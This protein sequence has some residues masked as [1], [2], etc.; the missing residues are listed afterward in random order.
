MNPI[1]AILTLFASLTVLLAPR[2]VAVIGVFA[3]ICY[4]TQ[5]QMLNVGGFHFHAIRIVLLAGF[6]RIIVRG[7]LAKLKLSNIDWGVIA[8][9][10]F[11]LVV[12]GLRTGVWQEPVGISYNILLSYFVFRCFITG[13]DDFQELL[14]RLALLIVPL[15]LC[16]VWESLTGHNVFSFMGGQIADWER[17][18]RYRC[19]GSFRGPHTAG[20]FGATLMPLF[21]SLFFINLQRRAAAVA[22]FI[23]A[24]AITYTSNSS[25]PLLAYL[26]C[27]VGLGFWPLRHRMKSVRMGIVAFLIVMGFS[28]KAPIWYIFSKISDITGGDGWH[29]SYLMEQ[30]FKH[31]SDWWFAG[32]DNTAAWAATQ[33]SWGGADITN[34]YVSCAS[35]AGL[36]CLVLFILILVRCFRGLGLA[37]VLARDISPQTEGLL[38]CAGCA[39][40]GHM[41]NLFSVTYFDQMDVAWWGFLAII[42]TITSSTEKGALTV[43]STQD[44]QETWSGGQPAEE[45]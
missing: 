24:T 22:G 21:V 44:I 32:T 2:R 23:A 28:M 13:W 39:L 33:M 11:T 10:F 25:G 40:F 38:W 45:T 31:F 6:I 1:G 26:S 34:Q 3:A 5:G 43:K 4:I 8:Y 36:G 7:E 16:M 15:A 18:G 27:V 29:R 19:V 12:V 37:L 35:N 42:S 9:T 14:P 20:T 17:E 30:C 41:V